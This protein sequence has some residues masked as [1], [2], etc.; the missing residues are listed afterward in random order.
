MPKKEIYKNLE[1]K[2]ETEPIVDD[3]VQKEGNLARVTLDIILCTVSGADPSWIF[4][5]L[6]PDKDVRI[7]DNLDC[8]RSWRLS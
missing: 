2:N 8:S 3:Y 5:K 4:L 7:C 1:P 6:L